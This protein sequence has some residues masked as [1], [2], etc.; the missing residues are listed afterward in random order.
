MPDT[1]PMGI[2]R[3]RARVRIWPLVIISEQ[4]NASE[5]TTRVDRLQPLY[6]LEGE[7][8]YRVITVVRM[9]RIMRLYCHPWVTASVYMP[10]AYLQARL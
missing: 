9:K 4:F 1:E 8:V 2:Y 7:E 3:Y 10:A 6:G 5:T